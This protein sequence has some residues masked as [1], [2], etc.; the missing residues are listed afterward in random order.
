MQTNS[1]M[2][3]DLDLQFEKIIYPCNIPLYVAEQEFFTL[4]QKL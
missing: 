2:K 1:N 4:K 3:H